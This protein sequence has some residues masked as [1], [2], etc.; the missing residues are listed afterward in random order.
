MPL[1]FA[2]ISRA[3]LPHVEEW[4]PG[5]RH[6]GREYLPLN[7]MRADD[8]PGS[9][10]INL[11]TGAWG[12]FAA[13][14]Q[15]GDA[16]SLWAYLHHNGD[17]AAAARELAAR[18]SVGTAPAQPART[19]QRSEWR[20]VMPVPDGVPAAP[21]RYS[22]KLG[23]EWVDLEF[24]HRWAYESADGK[25]LGYAVRFRLP[26]GSKDVVP[27][28]YCTTEGGRGEWRWLSFPKPR[29]LYNLP[30]LA[31]V[32]DRTVLLVE[33]E[34][35]AD[36]AGQL[37][38]QCAVL[39]WPGGGKAAK[40]AD[41]SPVAQRRVM[42]WPDR[43]VPGYE[44]AIAIAR[45]L[46]EIRCKV[47]IVLPPDFERGDGWDLADD[48]AVNVQ[49]YA[50]QNLHDVQLFESRVAS[51]I[52]SARAARP[53][54]AP[55][56][57]DTVPAGG[58]D[59]AVHAEGAGQRSDHAAAPEQQ[60]VHGA[61]E[62]GGG[63]SAGAAEA[64]GQLIGDAPFRALGYKSTDFKPLYYYM[65]K[66]LK[67]VVEI[68]K[69]SDHALLNIAPLTF[70]EREFPSRNGADWQAAAN[71]LIGESARAGIFDYE[72]LRGRGAWWDDGRVVLHLGSRL[73]VD[74]TPMPVD[75]VASR[76]IYEAATP[77]RA[78]TD[79]PLDARTAHRL[80]EL[81]EMLSWELPIN[82]KL[83]AGWCFIAPICGA[84]TWRPHIWITGAAGTGK[85]WVYDN[86]LKR[87]LG[88]TALAVQSATTE[89]GLRQTL[90]S[91]ALPVI[92]DEAEAEDKRAQER[93][94]N[95]LELMRQASSDTGAAIIKGSATGVAKRY[96]IR[97]MFAFSSVNVGLQFASDRTRVCV[98]GM[99]HNRKDTAVE[100][101]RAIQQFH[102]EHLTDEFVRRLHAR[103]IH[104]IPVVRKNAVTFATAGAMH[105]GNQRLG[106]R[107]GPLLAGAYALH[108]D[109]LVALEDARRWMREQNWS[110]E[111]AMI[112]N[113]DEARLWHTLMDHQM[114]VEGERGN[115]D[116]AVGELVEIALGRRSDASVMGSAAHEVLRRNGFKVEDDDDVTTVYVHNTHSGIKRMLGGTPWVNG[117]GKVL[118]RLPNATSGGLQ[119]FGYGSPARTVAVKL[120]RD[121]DGNT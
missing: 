106:D 98:L 116:R 21:N 20:A 72:R 38:P 36:A 81:C 6:N 104:M 10:S 18:Y 71:W 88:D 52:A 58:G 73:I 62:H 103:A 67:Q 25:L 100:D 47:K 49:E 69:H 35:A 15:G 89:A 3:A 46:E 120:V 57:N 37:F 53:P 4:L 80:V 32:P 61:G 91:D 95:V 56:R 96:Q 19:P 31:A 105:F 87:M 77:L 7:P 41:W 63:A 60:G 114:R 75:G 44:T 48:S 97:S 118:L 109:R 113:R 107:V 43:D 83:L 112:E 28:S 108:S 119:R 93:I 86:V 85:S 26:D 115:F 94:Q 65:P 111:S 50:R 29:P 27:Q 33:G 5:G 24:V 101:F 90:G 17:Q 121:D 64:E 8:S 54:S 102:Y 40:H 14:A 70:W 66:G 9:F 42:I 16:V 74:N 82:G 45:K 13:G 12:D 23:D 2:A 76:F 84:L 99:A 117:W 55:R 51:L 30:A 92:F 34:K 11:D 59:R 110:D 78:D 1:D 39:T 68:S 79:N 22:K